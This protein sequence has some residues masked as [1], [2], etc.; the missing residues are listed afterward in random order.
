[1]TTPTSAA[2]ERFAAYLREAGIPGPWKID[3][4]DPAYAIADDGRPAIQ[5]DPETNERDDAK[6]AQRTLLVVVAAAVLLGMSQ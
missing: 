3:E 6:I 1:M 4:T 5:I 2:A